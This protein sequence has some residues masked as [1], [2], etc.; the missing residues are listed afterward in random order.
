MLNQSFSPWRRAASVHEWPYHVLREGPPSCRFGRENWRPLFGLA[1]L[2]Q[3]L[4][5]RVPKR[6]FLGLLLHAAPAGL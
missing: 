3:D 6:P 2:L 5:G 4:I 1:E